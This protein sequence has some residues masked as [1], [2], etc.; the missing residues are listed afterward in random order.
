MSRTA[1]G[2]NEIARKA[3]TKPEFVMP[4]PIDRTRGGGGA[5][6]DQ[7]DIFYATS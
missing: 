7:D 4:L 1:N 6:N 2:R 3:W 5:I